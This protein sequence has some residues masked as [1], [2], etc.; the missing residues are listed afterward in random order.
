VPTEGEAREEEQAD[1]DG[2]RN[3]QGQGD[4]VDEQKRNGHR[5]RGGLEEGSG[6]SV[7]INSSHPSVYQAE[8]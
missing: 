6:N 2:V 4:I 5:S 7:I 1:C 3:P 8:N